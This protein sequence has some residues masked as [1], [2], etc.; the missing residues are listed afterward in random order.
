VTVSPAVAAFVAGQ[1]RGVGH[2][3]AGGTVM[4]APLAVRPESDVVSVVAAGPVDVQVTVAVAFWLTP[5]ASV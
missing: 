2:R 1:G 3:R 4:V 5:E